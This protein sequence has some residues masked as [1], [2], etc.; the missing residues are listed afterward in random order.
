MNNMQQHPSFP[1]KKI[2][3]VQAVSTAL[4]ILLAF[5]FF[6]STK[7]TQNHMNNVQRFL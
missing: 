4:V 6:L 1:L 2:L 7:S 3:R 5:N